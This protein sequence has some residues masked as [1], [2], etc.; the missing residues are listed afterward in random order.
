MS[1][2][3]I[4]MALN[5]ADCIHHVLDDIDDS[6]IDEVLVVDGG[7]T[8]GT[9]EIV[10][11]FGYRVLQQ[12]GSGWGSAFRTGI[13]YAT[14]DLITLVDADGSY[15]QKDIPLLLNVLDEGY[16]IAYGSRYLPGARS[17]DDTMIRWFGNMLF[18]SLV[19]LVHGVGMSDSLFLFIAARKN[20][21]ESLGLSSTGFEL[22]V[23]FPIKAHKMGYTFKEIASIEKLRI[24]GDSKVNALFDGLRI[25]KRIFV[26]R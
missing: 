20:L 7:S 22:C 13:K 9:Q 15:E 10:E 2:T 17:D 11:R 4:I 1:V 6:L 8:D 24:A 19:N 26:V 21:I 14:G 5:E 18:T 12:E 16:D 3:L 25:L 23:E